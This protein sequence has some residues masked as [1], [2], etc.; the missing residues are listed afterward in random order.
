MEDTNVK[1]EPTAA[2]RR[3]FLRG[4]AVAAG[5]AAAGSLATTAQAQTLYAE[6]LGDPDGI[7]A[8]KL[9]PGK[10]TLRLSFDSRKQPGIY[11]I[12]ELIVRT[13]GRT[14][15]PTCGLVG[16]DIRLGLDEIIQPDSGLAAN[17][18]IEGGRLPG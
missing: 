8:V 12:Q 5:A 16:L 3:V 10:A 11:D 15:C 2:N 18:V 1:K 9:H 13:L 17:A 6:R 14:G 7:P 4:A